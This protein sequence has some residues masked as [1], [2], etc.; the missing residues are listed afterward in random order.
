MGKLPVI[1]R[2]QLWGDVFLDKDERDEEG[3]TTTQGIKPDVICI[4]VE[5]Q[6]GG[7]DAFWL[8]LEYFDASRYRPA[9]PDSQDLP[10]KYSR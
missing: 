4:A 1:L 7:G 10:T 3:L 5:S 6:D 2:C 9:Y 8:P